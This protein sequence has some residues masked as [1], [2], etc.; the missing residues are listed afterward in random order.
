[1]GK[2][3]FPVLP[4]GKE[5]S[6]SP[7]RRQPGP[8]ASEPARFPSD[9]LDSWKAIANHLGREVRTVQLWEKLEGLP[10]HRHFHRKLGSVYAFRSEVDAWRQGISCASAGLDSDFRKELAALAQIGRLQKR[11]MVAVLPLDSLGGAPE[12]ESFNAGLTV[13]ITTALGGL[14]SERLGVISRASVLAYGELP[15]R[16]GRLSKDLN[17]RYILEGTTQVELGRIRVNVALVDVKD[18][19]TIWSRNY[20]GS[21]ENSFPVQSRIAGQVAQSVCQ[22]FFSGDAAVPFLPLTRSASRDTYFLGRYFWKQRS[23]EALRKAVRIFESAIQEEPQFALA[24]S[25]LADCLTLLSFYGIVPPDEAM[26]AARRAALKSV[27][28]DP[29][30]AEAHTSLAD[31][32]FHFDR[33]WT[34]ADQEYR[35]AIQCNPRYGLSYHWYAN[36]L[37]AKGQ[38]E[39]A[40]MAIMQALDL[41]PVS[42][43]TTVWAG[44]ISHFARRY[45][46]A[47][48][49]Y[50][51]AL[52]LDPDFAWAHMFMAQTL[53]QMDHMPEAVREFERT[54][55]LSGGSQSA[56][57]M[58]AHAHAVS[59]NKSMALRIVED[60]S[61]GRDRQ[62]VPSYDIAAVHAALGDSG[63]TIAWLGRAC[64]EHN[65]KLFTVAQDPRFDTV[66]R[67]SE[68]RRLVSQVGLTPPAPASRSIITRS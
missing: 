63:A 39:A 58:M 65:M 54:I 11:V 3:E 59:G 68:F 50:R 23:E 31:I 30:S 9:R 24:H 33:D 10:V 19:T 45:D 29:Y 15:R 4:H 5:L 60:L 51:R 52:E 2:T 61:G 32:L 14:C 35:A 20:K 28:L 17:V 37:V 26:P 67:H 66:R 48:R 36:L 41:D 8:Q 1:M 42:P 22:K 18:K 46:E 57:A 53:E 25:G 49:H 56:R 7:E 13:E 43:I 12:L 21:F 16:A 6:L 55:Q 34:R 47:L 62:N 64:A 38:H 27:E 44:V 40:H